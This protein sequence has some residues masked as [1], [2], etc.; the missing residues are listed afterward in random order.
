MDSHNSGKIVLLGIALITLCPGWT[1]SAGS[2]PSPNYEPEMKA[3]PVPTLP[4]SPSFTTAKQPPDAFPVPL[5]RGTDS[6]YSYNTQSDPHMPPGLK[7]LTIT[8]KDSVETVREFYR[9]AMPAGGWQPA[10]SRARHA[11]FDFFPREERYA[12]EGMECEINTNG[13]S[14][15]HKVPQ[16]AVVQITVTRKH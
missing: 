11:S 7:A 15:K 8:T 5:F 10:P 16:Q 14:S 2:K 6:T 1:Q 4:K 3:P 13:T 12:K 9:R